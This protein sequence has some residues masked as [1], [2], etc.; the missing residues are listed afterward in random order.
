M[1]SILQF[2]GQVTKA[3]GFAKPNR[4]RVIVDLF[5]IING[6]NTGFPFRALKVNDMRNSE[7]LAFFCE[8]ATFPQKMFEVDAVQHLGPPRIG[9]GGSARFDRFSLRFYVGRDMMEKKIFDAWLYAIEHPVTN[10]QNF[11]KEYSTS[12]TIEQYDD[13]SLSPGMIPGAGKINDVIS[14]TTNT[15][16]RVL[17]YASDIV[18]WIPGR[19][20][21]TLSGMTNTDTWFYVKPT[22]TIELYDAFPTFI[23]PMDLSYGIQ[24]RFHRVQVNFAFRKWVTK[25]LKYGVVSSDVNFNMVDGDRMEETLDEM[26]TNYANMPGFLGV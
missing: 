25:G 17:G 11:L 2:Q 1:S 16:N 7:R 20:G 15:V 21:S 4:Y 23:N 24:D 8:A 22:Y 18:N 13:L 14:K 3:L 12:I 19:V 26:M 6:S 9:V 10:E 5:K